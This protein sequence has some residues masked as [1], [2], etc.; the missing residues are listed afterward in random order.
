MPT[1]C[2]A[3]FSGCTCRRSSRERARDWRSCSVSSAGTTGGCG[4]NP[5]WGKAPR[6]SSPLGPIHRRPMLPDSGLIKNKTF[7]P[8]RHGVTE[9]AKDKWV[10]F[11]PPAPGG[12]IQ[13]SV[14]IADLSPQQKDEGMEKQRQGVF[15]GRR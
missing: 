8:R 3:S 7:A 1:N 6:C 12:F 10:L 4:P 11:G 13:E 9:K 15:G 2:S 14:D 5:V